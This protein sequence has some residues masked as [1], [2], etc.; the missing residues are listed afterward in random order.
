MTNLLNPTPEFAV[1][2]RRSAFVLVVAMVFAL[3]LLFFLA[4]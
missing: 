2:D 4:V 3:V 1:S